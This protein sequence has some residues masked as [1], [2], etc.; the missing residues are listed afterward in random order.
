[1]P[2][3]AGERVNGEAMGQT[4]AGGERVDSLVTGEGQKGLTGGARLRER[5]NA[6][7]EG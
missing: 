4:M 3:R 1:M 6:R 2:N 5:A 7:G